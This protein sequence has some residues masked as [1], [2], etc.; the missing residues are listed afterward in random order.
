MHHENTL[1]ISHYHDDISNPIY[2]AYFKGITSQCSRTFFIDYFHLIGALGTQEAEQKV[3]HLVEKE[4]ITLIFIIF[5][6]GDPILSPWFIQ[7]LAT[8]RFIAMAFWDTEQFFEQIDRYYAQLA[9]LVILACND[10]YIYKLELLG[11]HAICPFSLF[12]ST[13]YRLLPQEPTIDVSFVGEVTK[14]KRQEYIAFLKENNINIQAFGKGTENGK[15][16]FDKM[17]EIFNQS[18]INLSFT[19]TYAN[20]IYSF[21]ASINDHIVQNKGKPIEIALCGGFILS[22]F[23]PSIQNVFEPNSIDTFLTKEELLE[24][25]HY[26]LAHDYERKAMAQKSYEY[27]KEYYDVEK[28]FSKI[29]KHIESLPIKVEK[30]LILDSIFLKIHATFHLFYAITFFLQ[31]RFY[32]AWQECLIALRTKH[33][34]WSDIFTYVKY[35]YN[36]FIQLSHIKQKCNDICIKLKNENIVIYGS[37]AHTLCLFHDIKRLKKLKITAIADKNTRLWGQYLKGILIIPPHKIP[38]YAQH[39]LIS[40]FAFEEEIYNELQS[41]FG[42]SIELH[43][44]Y[45]KKFKKG[46]LSNKNTDPYQEY[47]DMLNY[48]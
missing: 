36:Y 12:D 33:I 8:N 7:K 43:K 42:S 39:V 4:K 44:I 6:S 21:G 32:L 41:H 16:S 29:F 3:Q 20:E 30:P 11:I 5:V 26:Y 27:A 35:K 14:G 24:K 25:V 10:E 37:G 38:D 40:S 48:K 23:V 15:V 45:D 47:R 19:G 18:K 17:L 2:G 46:L 28:A 1:I 31:K 34:M 13:K 9:D 22:E